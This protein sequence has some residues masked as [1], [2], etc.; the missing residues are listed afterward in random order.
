MWLMTTAQSVTLIA[1]VAAL[2]A[3]AHFDWRKDGLVCE[4]A[5]PV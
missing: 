5:L 4:L 3:Q 2:T 1:A